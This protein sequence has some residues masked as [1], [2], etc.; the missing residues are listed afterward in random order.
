[1]DGNGRVEALVRFVSTTGDRILPESMEP[2][3]GLI[4]TVDAANAFNPI[5]RD[6]V[7]SGFEVTSPITASTSFF[8]DI[9]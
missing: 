2:E 8:K 6:A 7:D 9:Y 4:A 3:D 5:H 1:M